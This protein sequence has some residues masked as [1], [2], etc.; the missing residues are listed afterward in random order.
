MLG[1]A[2]WLDIAHK[3]NSFVELG[4]QG[5]AKI[6]LKFPVLGEGVCDKLVGVAIYSDRNRRNTCPY[7]SE[8]FV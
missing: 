6:L 1:M 3:F 5:R 7:F 2:L 8:Q 4:R